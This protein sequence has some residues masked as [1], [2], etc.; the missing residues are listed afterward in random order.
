MPFTCRVTVPR[1]VTMSQRLSHPDSRTQKALTDTEIVAS[2]NV[3][4]TDSLAKYP[5][6]ETRPT[7][8]SSR[9]HADRDTTST[10][11]YRCRAIGIQT[12]LK[13]ACKILHKSNHD[14]ARAIR[15]FTSGMNWKTVPPPRVQNSID[16]QNLCL[17]PMDDFTMPTCRDSEF[18]TPVVYD[19]GI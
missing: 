3:P 5:T 10:R 15:R 14:T 6:V 12:D 9:I 4:E 17:F 13:A 18:R 7:N 11:Q 2:L 1:P 16:S 8:L 19:V